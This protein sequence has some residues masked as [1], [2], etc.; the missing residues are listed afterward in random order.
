MYSQTICF[1]IEF[2][3]ICENTRKS[4]PVLYAF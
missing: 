3:D 1:H 2:D 4:S